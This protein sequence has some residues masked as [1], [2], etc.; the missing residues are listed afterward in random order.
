MHRLA[1]PLSCLAIAAGLLA[2]QTAH[3]QT[4]QAQ[5]APLLPPAG[6]HYQYWPLQI[7]QWV[8]PE[9]PY[10][11]I[12][13]YID[14]RP[15]EPTYDATLTERASGKLV[16]YVNKPELVAQDK[17]KG[18]EAFLTRMQYDPPAEPA[19]GAQYGL[20]FNTEKGV[21]VQW[22]FVQGTDVSEQG[23]GVT[24]VEAPFPIL[25]Y[26]EQGALAGEGTALKI[27][28]VT[29]TADVWKEYAQPPFFV[30]YHGVVTQGAHILSI[31]PSANT[32]TGGQPAT[33]T[34][35]AAWKLA[36]ATGT[37]YSAHAD[38]VKA[39]A[40]TVILADEAAG[41][42]MTLDAQQ[43]PAGWAISRVR[44][45]PTGA[46]I[47]H[48]L[49]LTFLPALAP[50]AESRFDIVAGKKTKL[51]SGSVQTG[52]GTEKWTMTAPDWAKGKSA[53]ATV[54]AGP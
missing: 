4:V 25:L 47:D 33:L 39:S 20:R 12:V 8:G 48:T 29:S 54:T 3:A 50:G 21:P 35:G 16:H 15:K 10:S 32:W 1:H 43:T 18:D 6:L 31:A 7:V 2:A 51:A 27:G 24:P 49:S 11:M 46:K 40:S 52:A 17:A 44:L 13:L 36:S 28:D 19:K 38:S 37:T 45:G 34:E 53:A 23:S 14:D 9:L 41:T 30:P 22:Q 26:R 42:A 5:T